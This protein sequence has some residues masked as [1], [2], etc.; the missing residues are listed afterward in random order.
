MTGRT[1]LL[2]VLSAAPGLVRAQDEV[3]GTASDAAA[4]SDLSR[5]MQETL[6]RD[7][8]VADSLA[9]RIERSDIGERISGATDPAQRLADIRKWVDANPD[10]AAHLAIGLAQDDQAGNHNFEETV[11]RNTDRSF[12]IDSARVRDSTYGHLRKSGLDSKLM[13]SDGEMTEEERREILKTMFEGQGSMS[14]QIITEAKSGQRPGGAAGA[15]G[16]GLAAGYYD[17]LSRLNLRGYS[18]QLMAL[19]SALNLRSV[20]GAPKLLETGKLDY[21][22]LS[23][24]AYGM[25]YDLRNLESRMR[26]QENYELARLAGLEGKYKPEQLLDPSVEAVL[27][28]KAAGAKTSPHFVARR[29]ALERATAALRDFEAGA[30]RPGS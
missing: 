14:N 22:T 10:S 6:R 30:E 17:R 19:Q 21:E 28:Q 8:S 3:A 7:P 26:L 29:L 25:H 4:Q 11:L 2:L 27:K 5:T 13:R 9:A 16:A 23:Y 18:P 20:P 15:A 1:L 12:K 24:P